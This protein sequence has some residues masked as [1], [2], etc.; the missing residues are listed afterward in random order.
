MKAKAKEKGK[1]RKGKGKNFER[2]KKSPP[3]PRILGATAGE[4]GQV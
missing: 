4:G 2:Y 3:S 1:S